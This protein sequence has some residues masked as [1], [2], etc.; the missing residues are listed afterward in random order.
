LTERVPDPPLAP[1]LADER[2]APIWHLSPVGATTD[3]VVEVALQAEATSVTPTR[4]A[5]AARLIT[6]L[7]IAATPM[8]CD[9]ATTCAT[10][11]HGAPIRR[12]TTYLNDAGRSQ[13]WA[14]RRFHALGA[15]RCGVISMCGDLRLL[16]MRAFEES[17][18][19]DRSC[20]EV[21]DCVSPRGVK[22]GWQTPEAPATA[23]PTL[24]SPKASDWLRR[25]GHPAIDPRIQAQRTIVRTLHRA[26][27]AHTR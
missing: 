12:S 13:Q 18:C 24:R 1:K 9:V 15:Q 17:S 20:R 2:V 16:A 27:L 19:T 7:R 10:D 6:T 25:K 3:D 4:M 8:P 14:S 26:H 11:H 5:T 23:M 21:A 22:A